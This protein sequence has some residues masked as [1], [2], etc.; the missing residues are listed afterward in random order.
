MKKL[1]FVVLFMFLGAC[2]STAVADPLVRMTSGKPTP[3]V[4]TKWSGTGKKVE[5]TVRKGEDPEAIAATIERSIPGVKAKVRSGTILV[6]GKTQ[7]AL[8]PELAK[9]DFS[10]QDVGA[11]AALDSAGFDS[12]S[13]LRA[14]KRADLEKQLAD[15]ETTGVAKV[16]AVDGETFPNVELKL[17]ILRAP[18]KAAAVAVRKGQTL[19]VVP[20][21]RVEKGQVDLSHPETQINLGAW[22]FQPGDTVRF[23]LGAQAKD[24]VEV[25]VISR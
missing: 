10:A 7:A 5:L 1:R 3:S 21:I 16:V 24:R 20:L 11:L 15:Q 14:K 2:G 6:I 12:G 4:V 22:Y 18:S 13:S 9:I 19:T 23:Q 25:Q 8:L 17:Q